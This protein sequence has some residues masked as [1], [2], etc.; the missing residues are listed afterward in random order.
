MQAEIITLEAVLERL[1]ARHPTGHKGSFG[2]L[3]LVTGSPLTPGAA[4]LCAQ[5]ALRSGVGLV[6]W[7]SD[8]ASVHLAPI[9]PPELMLALREQV[10]GG[11]DAGVWAEHIMSFGPNLVVGPGMGQSARACAVLHAIL[12]RASAPLCLDADALNLLAGHPEL[13][14]HVPTNSVCTPHP[15]EM[16]RLVHTS[17]ETI[18]KQPV[19]AALKLAA[20]RGCIIVLK[21]VSTVVAEPK[22][23]FAQT[24]TQGISALGHGGT[25][26]VLAGLLG[27]LLAQGTQPYLAAQAAVA[28]HR[29][30]GSHAAKKHGHTATTASD[31]ALALGDVWASCSR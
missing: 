30:A 1:P 4:I 3:T 2:S 10:V 11:D 25:G 9:R 28:L 14:E 8:T 23:R 22:G 19:D 20:H 24:P 26:D 21:G 29:A 12:R 13:W 17:V 18:L 31:V 27:G 5:G 6:R 7:A 15:K 16:S